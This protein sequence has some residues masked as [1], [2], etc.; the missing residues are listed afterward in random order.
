MTTL[1]ALFAS[2]LTWMIFGASAQL[3]LASWVRS[4]RTYMWAAAPLVM[5]VC[6]LGAIPTARAGSPDAYQIGMGFGLLLAASMIASAV[7]AAMNEGILLAITTTYW[8]S[9]LVAGEATWWGPF[10]LLPAGLIAA[11]PTAVLVGIAA[12]DHRPARWLRFLL[13]LWALFALVVVGVER[14]PLSDFAALEGSGRG[15]IVIL[16]ATYLGAHIAMLVHN[17]MSV[18]ILI[19]FTG[20]DQTFNQRMKDIAKYA[21]RLIA[22]YSPEPLGWRSALL[23][24]VGQGAFV[25]L[26]SR[27][28][29]E[30]AWLAVHACLSLSLMAS[31]FFSRP[32]KPEGPECLPTG[33]DIKREERRRRESR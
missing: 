12:T 13:Y 23:I 15:W 28:R 27:W 31:I 10:A 32:A 2:P 3:S 9:F 19:P 4:P 30:G 17:V 29:P 26:L 16:A 5:I 18:L 33:G 20:E 6:L 7:P 25:W 1:S 22:C 14:F 24:V 21:A 8:I 11:V